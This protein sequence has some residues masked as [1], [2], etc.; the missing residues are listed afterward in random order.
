MQTTPSL[1]DVFFQSVTQ[2]NSVKENPSC[3]NRSQTYDLPITSSDALPLSYRR[4]MG[5]KAIELSTFLLLIVPVHVTDCKNT[6]VI[7]SPDLK[8]FLSHTSS[9]FLCLPI[10]AVD[11]LF[12]PPFF[13]RNYSTTIF[14]CF[15]VMQ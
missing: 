10:R 12:H 7:Y 6:F 3:P 11:V 13:V 1:K 15:T 14:N 2:A 9:L 5:A 4:L 8:T